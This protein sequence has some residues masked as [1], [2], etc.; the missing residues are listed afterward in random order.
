VAELVH[1]R[2]SFRARHRTAPGHAPAPGPHYPGRRGP[3][4]VRPGRRRGR[5]RRAGRN[6]PGRG[7][8]PGPSLPPFPGRTWSPCRPLT[9]APTPSPSACPP[10]RT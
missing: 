1:P 7:P 3:S 8:D 10:G 9:A 2:S 4:R 5:G 6:R